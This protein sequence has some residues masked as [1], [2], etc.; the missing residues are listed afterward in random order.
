MVD[1]ESKIK[2][3]MISWYYKQLF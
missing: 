2:R 3:A 1:A